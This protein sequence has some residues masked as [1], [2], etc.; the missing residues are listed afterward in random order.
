M[1]YGAPG[2]GAETRSAFAPA[3]GAAVLSA[4]RTSLPRRRA[5]TR[6]AGPR[7]RG[8]VP[9]G[10][11]G[12]REK[13][14][15][16][17]PIVDG[18]RVAVPGDRARL[19]P[20]GTIV[21]L[22]RD[23]M[24]VNSGGEKVFVEEVEEVLRRHPDVVDALVV[25]RPSER[26]GEEVVGVVQLRAAA[27]RSTGELREFAARTI[28]RFK[29]PRAIAFCDAIRRHASGKPDYPWARSVAAHAAAATAEG[30]RPDRASDRPPHPQGS[31]TSKCALHSS[32][33]CFAPCSARVFTKLNS[34]SSNCRLVPKAWKR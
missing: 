3:A 15:A 26:F 31:G 18:Q 2:S 10:Y 13:T 34:P 1:A 33:A 9:L 8:R 14:E 25:G 5:T 7:A 6:S 21:L 17:F 24:V 4:D 16:T 29:A 19:A 23:S 12:D 22:G 20:D 30:R 28:A 27:R 32:K 11:L